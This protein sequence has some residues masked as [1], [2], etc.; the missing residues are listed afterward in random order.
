MTV[1][2]A[3]DLQ[4]LFQRQVDNKIPSPFPFLSLME[5]EHVYNN[6]YYKLRTI[7]MLPD[8][9]PQMSDILYQLVENTVIREISQLQD[10]QQPFSRRY[11]FLKNLIEKNGISQHTCI[12]CGFVFNGSIGLSNHMCVH[13]NIITPQEPRTHLQSALLARLAIEEMTFM[14]P[15]DDIAYD[16]LKSEVEIDKLSYRLL[17]LKLRQTLRLLSVLPYSNI[18]NFLESINTYILTKSLQINEEDLNL[19][20]L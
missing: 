15:Q 1:G 7:Y 16:N 5:I 3:D 8:H 11:L 2:Y 20:E 12:G 18:R 4:E 6:I 17:V 14:S 9:A 10:H 19:F 13:Y